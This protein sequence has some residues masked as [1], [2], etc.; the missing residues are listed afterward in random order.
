MQDLKIAMVQSFQH[1][2]D[3][4]ANLKMFGEKIKAI[5]EPVDIIVLPEMFSTGFSMNP[6]ALF[7][8]MD[9]K[10]VGWMKAFATESIIPKSEIY[11]YNYSIIE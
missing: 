8:S 1:W 6:S 11:S 3:I 7:E 5:K 9:G 2:E 10:A 4:D